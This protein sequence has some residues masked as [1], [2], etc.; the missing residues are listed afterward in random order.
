M[1]VVVGG[2]ISNCSGRRNGARRKQ[3][4][5]NGS[6]GELGGLRHRCSARLV[7]PS[8]LYGAH[9]EMS[10]LDVTQ[11]SVGTRPTGGSKQKVKRVVLQA[12]QKQNG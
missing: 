2:A 10:E 4:V 1:L 7:Y 9:F 5:G 3:T 8:E 11:Q 6:I 12:A